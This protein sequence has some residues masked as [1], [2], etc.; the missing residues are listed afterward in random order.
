MV[1]GTGMPLREQATLGAKVGDI[2]PTLHGKSLV[3]S[4]R[5]YMSRKLHPINQSEI[6]IVINSHD[7]GYE[8]GAII[9]E[10][11]NLLYA[12]AN[13]LLRGAGI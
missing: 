13:R 4:E 8:A 5:H 3:I 12:E 1:V 9:L 7:H 10:S 2:I 6:G 11:N